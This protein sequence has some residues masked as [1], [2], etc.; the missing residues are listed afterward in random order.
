VA[1]TLFILH[2]GGWDVTERGWRGPW[3]PVYLAGMP[4][5]LLVNFFVVTPL[6]RRMAL[7]GPLRRAQSV[8]LGAA[9]FGGI[10]L[11]WMAALGVG[12]PTTLAA[13]ADETLRPVA[14]WAPAALGLAYGWL[15][16]PAVFAVYGGIS[17]A[18]GWLAAFG[19]RDRIDAT[20]W[21]T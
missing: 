2:V 7:A 11:V 16:T 18:V 17:A 9:V 21:L 4:V 8:R 5:A 10:T 6:L 15:L 14:V 13:W 3:L 20:D 12:P 19:R 1:V